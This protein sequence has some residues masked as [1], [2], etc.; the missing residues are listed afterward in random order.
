MLE[1]GIH[2]ELDGMFPELVNSVTIIELKWTKKSTELEKEPEEDAPTML[3]P[4]KI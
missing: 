1:P 2:L 4:T 3:L